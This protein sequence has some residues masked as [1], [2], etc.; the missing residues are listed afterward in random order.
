MSH[1]S[2]SDTSPSNEAASSTQAEPAPKAR[3]IAEL[4]ELL[5]RASPCSHS[6]GD[7]STNVSS[8]DSDQNTS[9]ESS[10]DFDI[11]DRHQAYHGYTSSITLKP[12]RV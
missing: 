11:A 5:S 4:P 3:K 7:E 6:Q 12:N 8:D 9:S 10:Y 1:A 2:S